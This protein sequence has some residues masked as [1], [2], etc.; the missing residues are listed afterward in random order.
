MMRRDECEDDKRWILR[1]ERWMEWLEK[2]NKRIKIRMHGMLRRNKWEDEKRWN[3]WLERWMGGR[4]E[5]NEKMRWMFKYMRT[6]ER[7]MRRWMWRWKEQIWL[8]ED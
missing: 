1:S 7:K 4:E 8:C 6:N 2:M 5:M 3:E